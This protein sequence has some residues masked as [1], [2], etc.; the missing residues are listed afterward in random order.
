MNSHEIHFKEDSK[1]LRFP[2]NP[3]DESGI[4]GIRQQVSLI[5]SAIPPN[6]SQA[7]GGGGGKGEGGKVLEAGSNNVNPVHKY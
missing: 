2:E 5:Q 6:S 4:C 1:N 3:G 7:V